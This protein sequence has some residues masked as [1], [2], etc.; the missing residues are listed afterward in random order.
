MC[1]ELCPLLGLIRGKCSWPDI[2]KLYEDISF[3]IKEW[4]DRSSDD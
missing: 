3:S 2:I 1:V 4:I